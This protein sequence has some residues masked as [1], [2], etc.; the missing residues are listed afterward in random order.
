MLYI[1]ISLC[2]HNEFVVV[3]GVKQQGQNSRTLWQWRMADIQYL[4]ESPLSQLCPTQLYE[5]MSV[6]YMC[7]EFCCVYSVLFLQTVILLTPIIKT[8]C[9]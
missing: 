5:T 9:L 2:I 3:G 4:T 7:V 6:V 8:C 1:T